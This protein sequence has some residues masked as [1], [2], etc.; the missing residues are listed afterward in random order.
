MLDLFDPPHRRI[1]D[2]REIR[3]FYTKY[4]EK[5]PEILSERASDDNLSSR[6]RRHW[7]RLARKARR[8]QSKWMDE[9]KTG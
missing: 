2:E 9:L 4:R 7:R 3:Y 5:A 1:K 8:Q 6:D